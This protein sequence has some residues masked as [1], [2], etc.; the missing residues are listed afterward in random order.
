MKNKFI[1]VTITMLLFTGIGNAQYVFTGTIEDDTWNGAA[2]LSVVDDYRKISGVHAEQIISKTNI[3][4][5]NFEFKGNNLDLKNRIYRIHVDNCN[6]NEQRANHFDGHCD[7]SEE[8]IFIAN[9]KDTIDLPISSNKQMFCSIRST[10]KKS[11]VFFQI[12][13]L[14]ELMSYDYG[15]FR[16]EANRKLN[17]TKWFSVFQQFGEQLEEPLAELYIYNF[18]SDRRSDLHEHYKKDISSN[19]YYNDLLDRLLIEY[20]NTSYTQQYAEELK[21]DTYIETSKTEFLFPWK[22]LLSAFLILSVLLNL[23]LWNRFKKLKKKEH[24]DLTKKLT[25]QEQKI[26]GLLLENKTNKEIAQEVFVS[27]STVKTH[28]N[29]VYKK[30]NITSR[31]QI[32]SLFNK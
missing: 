32:K 1:I 11:N 20:P 18:L 30:L 14:K 15:N 8:L 25:K 12:D 31:D 16:S 3:I 19:T 26:V 23:F 10:N 27:H 2:Y 29:N 28:I 22:F 13:S 9:N 24:L 7:N 6:D 21:L 4:N 17:N 5:N